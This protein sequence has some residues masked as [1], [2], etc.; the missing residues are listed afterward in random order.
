V[1]QKFIM[2]RI[3][4]RRFVLIA[5][6][7][8]GAAYSI[9]VPR[10]DFEIFGVEVKRGGDTPL[11]LTLGLDL[12][13]GSHLVYEARPA[14]EDS[15]PSEDQMEGI[16]K[17]IEKRVN[18]FGV[19]EPNIQR[20]GGDRVL[21]QLPGIGMSEGVIE[22]QTDVSVE[23]LSTMLRD[24]G[25]DFGNIEEIEPRRFKAE[26]PDFKSGDLSE[27]ALRLQS[28][29]PEAIVRLRLEEELEEGV[30]QGAF[31]ELGFDSAEIV[32]ES[33]YSYTVYLENLEALLS[34]TNSGKGVE[35]DEELIRELL[36]DSLGGLNFLELKRT[37]LT[38]TGGIEEAK[39]L[40]GQTAQLEIKERIC[41]NDTQNIL[42]NCDDLQF[43]VDND[44]GL[45]GDDL[46]R[47]YA[48][49]HPTLG[50]PVVNL[51]FTSDGTKIFAKHTSDIAGTRNR[52]AFFLDKDLIVAP[53][54]Q[55]AITTGR[56]FIQGPDFTPERVRVMAI[57]LE[58]G[59]LPV[60]LALIQEQQVDATLG[61]DS[62]GKSVVAGLI[63][64]A[65]VLLFMACYYRLP[66]ILACLALVCYAVIVLGILKMWPVTLSLG[67]LAAFVLSIGMAVD[68][69]ILIF[70]RMKEELRS[71]RTLAAAV[72]TGFNRAWPAIRDSNVAT[73]IT[74][75]ILFW[76]GNRLGTGL[77]TG[78][79][80]TLFIGVAISMFSALTITRSFLRM[81]AATPVG[82]F[83]W[84]YSP[85]GQSAGE[86]A[87]GRNERG[88]S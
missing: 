1:L 21:V 83:A 23:T 46:A 42:E 16:L 45:S 2:R 52:T 58:S 49:T 63:G 36:N 81:I 44:I 57:Q 55:Q 32:K 37:S 9:A 24:M 68:A 40:I 72:E 29:F 34:E 76:F 25:R 59:I 82:K 61:S 35:S 60:P 74:C 15:L 31:S 19:A 71:G 22:T 18:S 78:F 26:L 27:L 75:A 47:A 77:V 64:M 6:I 28:A 38:V 13:G 5:L 73:F 88:R 84:L 11:G 50:I 85:I 62:L 79:A 20:M 10:V 17:I 54:A 66:G 43:H 65:L 33:E 39:K 70:E 3:A 80:L 14:D 69:N 8:G 30:L 12:E 86:G 41:L 51:E 87:S 53:I 56:A 67:G 48:G 4:I 7:V